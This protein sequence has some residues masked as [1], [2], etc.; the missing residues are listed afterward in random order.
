IV[1][2]SGRNEMGVLEVNIV[3]DGLNLNRKLIVRMVKSIREVIGYEVPLIL[4]LT[5]KPAYVIELV[6]PDTA[7]KSSITTTCIVTSMKSINTSNIAETNTFNE[8]NTIIATIIIV[9]LI[10]MVSYLALRI[11]KNHLL[12]RKSGE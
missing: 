9:I 3:Y 11:M 4:Y 5:K 6:T 10:L 12:R 8:F 7:N 2:T 1:I